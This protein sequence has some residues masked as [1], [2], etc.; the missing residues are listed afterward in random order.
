MVSLDR[1]FNSPSNTSGFMFNTGFQ[2]NPDWIFLNTVLTSP[3]LHYRI[4]QTF[5]FRNFG[6]KLDNSVQKTA[7]ED[8]RRKELI[9]R[10]KRQWSTLRVLKK[11]LGNRSAESAI[12]TGEDEI[13]LAEVA[14]NDYCNQEN[15]FSSKAGMIWS[16]VSS[17]TIISLFLA[18]VSIESGSTVFTKHVAS[19]EDALFCFMSEEILSKMLFY[20]KA[21]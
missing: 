11:C 13:D 3:N 4:L 18:D 7:K 12:S 19:V 9:W 15:V 10:R 21:G 8:D 5:V 6:Y 2:W 1:D 17:D 20:S 16:S 14:S